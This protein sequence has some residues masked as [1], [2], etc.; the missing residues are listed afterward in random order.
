MPV[1]DARQVG[2][3][4]RL[5]F[6]G[7]VTELRLRLVN[8]TVNVVGSPDP[9]AGARVE[10]SEISGPP[11][12]VGHAGGVLEVGYEDVPWQGFLKL[13]DRK[14]WDRHAVVSVSVPAATRLSLAVVGASAVVSGLSGTAELRGVTGGLTLVGLSGPVRADTVS[15]DLEAQCL[16]GPLRFG[17]VGGELTLIDSRS[18]Q[19]RADAVSGGAVVDL[20]GGTPA[21]LNLNTVSGDIAV[22]LPAG[23]GATVR[24]ATTAGSA[25]C[26]FPE[27]LGAAP[28]SK[29]ISG[30]IGGGE[31]RIR[32]ASVSGGVALL[33]RPDRKD[34]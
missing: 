13:F 32:V 9:D 23:A 1:K 29:T 17:T 15:G 18:P 19:V 12:A 2:E 3:P 20:D 6:D 21:D 8:G 4:A 10:I 22:R 5:D 30:A 26:D 27:L 25:S 34:D 28:W 14:R 24:A 31:N 16:S 7:P 33:R 11:L